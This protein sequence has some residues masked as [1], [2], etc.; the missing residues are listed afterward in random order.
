MKTNN[1]IESRNGHDSN[2]NDE[3]LTHVKPVVDFKNTSGDGNNGSEV[4]HFQ[5]NKSDQSSLHDLKI[6]EEKKLFDKSHREEEKF[7]VPEP[8]VEAT[9]VNAIEGDLLDV[10]PPN[11]ELARIHRNATKVK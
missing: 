5:N 9:I 10:Y 6:N 8:K 3:N 2:A 1:F 4:D 7:V 11:F